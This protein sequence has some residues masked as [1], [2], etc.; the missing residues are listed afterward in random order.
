MKKGRGEGEERL[1]SWGSLQPAI[2]G[3]GLSKVGKKEE[4]D[5]SDLEFGEFYLEYK[6]LL[7]YFHLKANKWPTRKNFLDSLMSAV[8]RFVIDLMP[9]LP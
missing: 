1:L 9:V 8:L 2:L 3:L 5:R 6:H 7:R 4:N